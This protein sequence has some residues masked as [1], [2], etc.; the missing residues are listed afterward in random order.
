FDL[1][2]PSA[3]A[4]FFV[5]ELGEEVP[6]SDEPGPTTSTVSTPRPSAPP[7]PVTAAPVPDDDPLAIT[8]MACRLPGGVRSPEQLWRLIDDGV[9]AIG[10]F[11]DNRGW[12]LEGLYDPEPRTHCRTSARS[13]GFLYD[14][15]L[16]D[17]DF[18]GISPR[19]VDAMDPQ[20]RLL[21]ESSW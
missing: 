4:E 17:P 12:D 10:D 18:F 9:D 19:E 7:P 3:L 15:V 6:A 16:F 8:A 21:L 14:A 5:D 13:G 1:P 11:P 20:Q 2:A